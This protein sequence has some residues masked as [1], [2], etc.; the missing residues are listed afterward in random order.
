MPRLI[1]D[2]GP[3]RVIA[4]SNFVYTVG[5]GLYLTA[6]VLYFTQ[7][8]H[9]PAGQVGLGLGIAGLVSLAVGIV[10]GHLADTR[11]ARG[12]YAATLVVQALATAGFVLVD[13]FWTF[14]LAVCAAT[15]AKAAGLAARSPI[16]RRYGGDRPQE[17][18][19]HLRSVTNIGIS[20]GA[21]LAGWVVQVGTH[22]A[23]QLLV[24]GNAIG[25]AASAAVLV[26]LPPVTPG[27][28]VGG[29]RWIA[30]RDRPYLLITALDGIMA[31]QFKV[32]TVAV[33]LWLVAA[34]TAPP[35]LISGTMLI[36]TVIVV[37]FQVR[38][39]RSIDSP[40]TGG[41]AYRRSGVAFLVSCSL[42]SLSA[43]APAWAAATLLMTAVVIHTVGEL[44]H[45]AGG[46]EVS[47]ALA[48]EHATGQY[49]GVFGL[50]AGLAE[51]LGPG[52]LIALCITWGRP[53]WYVVG[54][55]FALTGL[56]AP[57]AVRWAQR[58]QGAHPTHIESPLKEL[59]A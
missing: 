14:V 51:A 32:L 1:P 22:T 11:G 43:G 18:R 27:P 45:S 52:L 10:V 30:L 57:F 21:L 8:V 36:N 34:T 35:W 12:V 16:I 9:L 33:P 37:A 23:Y 24:V 31:I 20:L 59:A 25:F 2:A 55:L 49:L 48:P 6:G 26:L 40:L 39:G 54:A 17:F 28:T 7:S 58:H 38:A 46:F 53:G 19:A 42:I 56:A 5:S 15:G 50:G 3:Q 41:A 44:W 29:P 13:S 4:A 47:F